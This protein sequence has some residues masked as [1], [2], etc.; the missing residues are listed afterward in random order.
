MFLSGFKHCFENQKPPEIYSVALFT[1]VLTILTICYIFVA[2]VVRN[3]MKSPK[4]KLFI[5]KVNRLPLNYFR[6]HSSFQYL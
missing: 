4:L 3:K 5:F 6:L 1:L 2:T